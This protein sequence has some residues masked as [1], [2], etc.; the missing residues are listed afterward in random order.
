M[1]AAARGRDRASLPPALQPRPGPAA[2]LPPAPLSEP[3]A[4]VAAGRAGASGVSAVAAGAP[5][6]GSCVPRSVC[7]S[8]HPSI[9]PSIYPSIHPCV[10][11]GWCVCVTDREARTARGQPLALCPPGPGCGSRSSVPRS[12]PRWGNLSGLAARPP[13]PS[14]RLTVTQNTAL[15]NYRNRLDCERSL[16]GITENL[17]Q[18]AVIS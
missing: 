18:L 2:R 15:C 3:A 14:W 11:G 16:S 10:G 12:P 6:N 1:R 7:P 8:V 9:Y 17:G 4:R 5:A 13:P